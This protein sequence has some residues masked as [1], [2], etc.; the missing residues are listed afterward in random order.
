[1]K[2]NQYFNQNQG[3]AGECYEAP[4]AKI[5]SVSKGDT[6]FVNNFGLPIHTKA[7]ENGWHIEQGKVKAFLNNEDYAEFIK[8]YQKV[9]AAELGITKID[10]PAD[11]N[12]Q[13]VTKGQTIMVQPWSDTDMGIETTADQDGYL[14]ALN[15]KRRFFSD[16]DFRAKF[17]VIA[18]PQDNSQ[19]F[20]RAAPDE[21][22]TSTRF[23]VLAEKVTF[24]FEEGPYTEEAGSVLFENSDDID[25]YTSV[26]NQWFRENF[27]VTKEAIVNIQ[28]NP[29]PKTP[30]NS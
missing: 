1:M 6:I 8:D 5:R 26:S 16:I 13:A 2:A 29:S 11:A 9:N 19:A 12:M 14:V 4:I 28:K 15:G 3:N 24:D 22:C 18:T 23:I 20:Y 17:N 7:D 27:A 30:S 25:G 21:S 10:L